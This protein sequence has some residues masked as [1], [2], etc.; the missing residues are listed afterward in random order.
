MVYTLPAAY[1]QPNEGVG[2][3]SRKGVRAVEESA[4]DDRGSNTV[5]SNR[6]VV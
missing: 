4:I 2:G 6:S 5:R 3:A 1:S